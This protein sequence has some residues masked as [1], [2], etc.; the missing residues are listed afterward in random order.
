MNVIISKKQE[1]RIKSIII[2]LVE[3]LN[4]PLVSKIDVQFAS[5]IYV[6]VELRAF[7]GSTSRTKYES[8]IRDRINNF[9]GLNVHIIMYNK[10]DN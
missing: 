5:T 2:K 6:L 9:I 7:L 8:L 10:E 1:D 3:D 4:V